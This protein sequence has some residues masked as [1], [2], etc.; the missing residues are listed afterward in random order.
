MKSLEKK[1][2]LLEELHL[3]DKLSGNHTL[4]NREGKYYFDNKEINGDEYTTYF[5]MIT[6]RSKPFEEV[7]TYE[8]W[9]LIWDGSRAGN[10]AIAL[11]PDN[12][13]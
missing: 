1:L 10:I 9:L 7:R 2:K 5:K 11:L 6:G 3:Q 13:R 8:D 4:L 12:G